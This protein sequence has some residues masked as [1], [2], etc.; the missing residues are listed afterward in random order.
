LD[1]GLEGKVALVRVA[2]KGP[3]GTIG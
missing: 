1:L 3:D 2:S